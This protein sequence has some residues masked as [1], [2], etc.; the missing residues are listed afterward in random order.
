MLNFVLRA[1][2]LYVFLCPGILLSFVLF[3]NVGIIKRT[4]YSIFLAI[5]A[6]GLIAVGLH[7]YGVSE[8]SWPSSL[9]GCS[10]LVSL[11]CL[12]YL[13]KSKKRQLTVQIDLKTKFADAAKAR[14][15]FSSLKDLLYIFICSIIGTLWKVYFLS[16]ISNI[17]DPYSYA[18]KFVGKSVPDLGFYT[19][20]AMDRIDFIGLLGLRKIEFLLI[21]YTQFLQSFVIT[22]LY[23]LL[24][25][26]LCREFRRE[27]WVA[28]A[29]VLFMMLGPIEIFHAVTSISGHSLGYIALFPLF[30]LFKSKPDE[31]RGLSVM[32]ALFAVLMIFTYS[33]PCIVMALASGCLAIALLIKRYVLQK[34][35]KNTKVKTWVFA[36]LAIILAGSAFFGTAIFRRPS[37]VTAASALT[38]ASENST[39]M[40]S[41]DSEQT[42]GSIENIANLSLVFKNETKYSDPLFLGIS[43]I[44]WQII[45]F[46]VCGLTFVW[47][48][49]REIRKKRGLKHVDDQE[50]DIALCIL[51]VFVISMAFLYVNLPA[52]IFDYFAFFGIIALYI[53]VR[54]RNF[55]V[56]AFFIFLAITGVV[57][58]KD[59]K[60]F[61]DMSPSESAGAQ[62]V[63][64][65]LGTADTSGVIFTDMVFANQLIAHEYFAVTGA[66][67]DSE[68]TFNLF[69]S[70][71]KTKFEQGRETLSRKNISYIA[72]TKRM[73][74]QYVLMLNYPQKGITN[75]V[76][77]ET[78]PPVYSNGDVLIYK[79][80]AK[81]K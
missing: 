46:F 36:L 17:S 41:V 54:G 2:G 63:K 10:I 4:A 12:G 22:F 58:M 7:L 53:P 31:I 76:F 51:P 40:R 75:T 60:V 3:P 33:T 38:S 73:R 29:G 21:G 13:V 5:S 26:V 56:A 11:I 43:S 30:L 74:E 27:R 69:Y 23:L 79:I 65:N 70:N 67:D 57:A 6:N 78:L 50:L 64:D 16:S 24:I 25:Y 55:I 61:F 42:A 59:K 39:K 68:L 20:T 14:N 66:D 44:G 19:G 80:Q 71:D 1:L 48:L 52:R 9:I 28:I 34:N 37:A 62:W 18:F 72:L 15:S 35:I 45:A 77:F 49:I 81:Q 32:T 47:F 8:A